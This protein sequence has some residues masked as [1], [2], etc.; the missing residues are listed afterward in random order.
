MKDMIVYIKQVPI[1]DHVT[2]DLKDHTTIREDIENI[3]NPA[4]GKA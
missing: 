3:L 1:I 4:D 2:L